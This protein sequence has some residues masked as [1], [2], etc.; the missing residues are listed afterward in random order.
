[1]PGPAHRPS[2]SL[3][4]TLH[5]SDQE[6]IVDH[7]GTFLISESVA[8]AAGLYAADLGRCL[9]GHERHGADAEDRRGEVV[10][11]AGLDATDHEMPE[12]RGVGADS[13][14]RLPQLQHI[15][16]SR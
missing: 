2:F 11:R 7:I 12:Q 1:M 5:S 6:G 14:W 9:A 13:R 16:D 10:R 8:A 15:D 3:G 4:R